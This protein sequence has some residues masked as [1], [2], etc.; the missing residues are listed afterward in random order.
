MP[1]RGASGGGLPVCVADADV[2][3]V[4]VEDGEEGSALGVGEGGE[5][6]GALENVA[7]DG[8]VVVGG[9]GDEEV[10]RDVEGL[11]D[12][13]GG[14]DGGGG[15][16]ALVLADGLSGDRGGLGEGG[17]GESVA[18]AE[19]EE[20]LTDGRGSGVGFGGGGWHVRTS[21]GGWRGVA[22]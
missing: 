8:A 2:S 18:L 3:E 15:L 17:L 4:G 5:L 12:A 10:D 7:V 14:V 13:G 21:K 20:A 9:A 19:P 16:V 22:A 6:A 1:Q 11:G